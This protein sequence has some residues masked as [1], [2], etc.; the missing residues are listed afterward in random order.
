MAKHGELRYPRGGRFSIETPREADVSRDAW[1]HRLVDGWMT[2]SQTFHAS[3]MS[4]SALIAQDEK[5]FLC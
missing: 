1:M 4:Q 2:Y 3:F 5:N